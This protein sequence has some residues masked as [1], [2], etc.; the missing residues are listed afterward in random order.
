L[1]AGLAYVIVLSSAAAAGA[2]LA[3]SRRLARPRPGWAT[4]ALLAGVAIP[5]V[6]GLASPGVRDALER[7]ADRIEDGELWRLV[8]A[9]V[10]QDGGVAGTV[11]NLVALLVLGSVAERLLGPA[12]TVATFLAVG[13]LAQLP[14][15]AWDPVGA[16]NS[17]GNFGLAGSIALV[18]LVARP[19][20]AVAGAALLAFAAGI[21]LLAARD[22][23]GA[24]FALGAAAGLVPRGRSR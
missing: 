21:A 18:A 3:E 24:A 7:D 10:Q 1:L 12:R 2:W 5:S 6:V 9:L 20:S 13:V 11:F 19:T 22:I 8:T 14:A 15:L 17:L 16:G 4:I 23:H